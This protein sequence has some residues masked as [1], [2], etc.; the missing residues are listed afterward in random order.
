MAK[1]NVAVVPE[2]G[3]GLR[4][5]VVMHITPLTADHA[6]ARNAQIERRVEHGVRSPVLVSEV[7]EGGTAQN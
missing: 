5:P 6:R 1:M 3:R 7:G 4:R 2:G